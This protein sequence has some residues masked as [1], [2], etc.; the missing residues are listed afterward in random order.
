MTSIQSDFEVPLVPGTQLANILDNDVTLELFKMHLTR[1]YALE[2][3]L[4]LSHTHSHEH[5]SSL[6][7][8]STRP[9][10]TLPPFLSACVSVSVY[11]SVSV[12]CLNQSRSYV[13]S[14]LHLTFVT[15]KVRLASI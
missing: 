15:E 5:L 9:F 14:Y 3:S 11:M 4:S 12:H 13:S 6:S 10:L 7:P 8:L 1:E 2:V